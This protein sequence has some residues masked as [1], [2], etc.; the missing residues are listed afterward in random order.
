V[1]NNLGTGA[2]FEGRW[3]DAIDL[4][5]RG[6]LAHERIGDPV[7]AATGI[8]NIAEILSDQ[9]R[10]DEAEPLLRKTL[11][12]VRAAGERDTA[13]YVLS[14]LGRVAARRGRYEEAL[15]TYE[16][17]KAL[18]A[19]VGDFLA[20]LETGARIAECLVLMGDAP[21][22]LALVEELIGRDRAL[23]TVSP[24]TPL[25]LRTRG[26]ALMRLGDLPA[27]R[28]ALDASL[29][30]ATTRRA[31]Y[32]IGVTLRAMTLLNERE[33][34]PDPEMIKRCAEILSTL[35]VIETADPP[36]AAFGGGSALAP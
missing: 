26:L 7:G 15:T 22:A 1:L 34:K 28:A 33:G 13:G 20:Q 19:D 31:D 5:E 9:G 16:Q 10:L 29:D 35:G 11:R 6:R 18:F 23:A 25:V 17:A 30:T 2:Y 3:D 21:G 12:T 36:Q 4:Y 24:L 14:Q 8:F 32:E 27:A